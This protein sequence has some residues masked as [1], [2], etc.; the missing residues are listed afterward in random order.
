MR[1]PAADFSEYLAATTGVAW[2]DF[3]NRDQ[4]R[5]VGPDRVS[6]VH[7]MVTN[8]IT[9]LAEGASCSI[10]MLTAKGAMVG[11]GRVTKLADAV[12]VD[13]GPGQGAAVK[14][15]LEKYLISEDAEVHE[16]GDLAVVG[17]VGPKA[18]LSLIAPSA[19]VAAMPGTL[20]S[21]F[22]VIIRREQLSAVLA[23]L[24]ALP[25]VSAETLEVLRVEAG[26]PLFGADM[27]ETTI[28]LEANLEK[29]IHYNKGCYIGQEVIARATYRG[30]MNKKLMGLLLGEHELSRGAELFKAD[31][32]VGRVTSVVRSEK[33][34][35]LIALAYVQRD[36]L[37]PGTVLELPAGAGTVT[38]S[39]LPFS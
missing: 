39:A 2:V 19:V 12:I 10:A 24:S 6:F 9:G 34:K 30:Q 31:K 32:R 38:V 22:D 16:A 25:K 18:E 36:H 17:L 4:L 21:G 27:T 7:G 14:A 1:V 37:A 11:D 15:F 35:Q 5:V 8:D 26:V 13:T 28:P 29:A 33:A 20:G 23:S 3:S